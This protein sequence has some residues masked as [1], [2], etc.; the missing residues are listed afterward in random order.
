LTTEW[1]DPAPTANGKV[2]PAITS[3][4]QT[5]LRRSTLPHNRPNCILDAIADEGNKKIASKTQ[6]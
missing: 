6:L 2:Y 5:L 4:G 1:T 3:F